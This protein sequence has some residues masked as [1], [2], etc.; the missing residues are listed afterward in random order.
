[1][2]ALRCHPKV[3]SQCLQDGFPSSSNTLASSSSMLTMLRSLSS[4]LLQLFLSVFVTSTPTQDSPNLFFHALFHLLLRKTVVPKMSLPVFATLE[5][6]P[7]LPQCAVGC[8]PTGS[9]SC[10]TSPHRRS[11]SALAARARSPQRFRFE[12]E[13]VP[14]RPTLPPSTLTICSILSE[15]C[16]WGVIWTFPFPQFVLETDTLVNSQF[17]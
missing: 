13:F 6:P 9:A 1:M 17:A 16:F 3:S 4:N 12:S 10:P 8:A 11:D 5:Q 7:F 2:C 15:M 14:A